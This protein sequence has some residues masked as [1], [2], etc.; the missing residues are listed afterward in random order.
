MKLIESER[1]YFDSITRK[2]NNKIS[3]NES[4]FPNNLKFNWNEDNF[5]PISI[6]KA[7]K[8]IFIN[9]KNYPL[10]KKLFRITNLIL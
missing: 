9:N 3:Y 4:F 2:I 10:Y 6:P 7:G 1:K 8:T 5:G